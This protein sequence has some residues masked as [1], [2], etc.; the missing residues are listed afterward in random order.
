MESAVV[1]VPDEI[2]GQAIVLFV[3]P[4]ENEKINQENIGEKIRLHL[5]KVIGPVIQIKKTFI[6]K[7]LPK[8]S[9]G[10]LMRRVLRC[11]LNG[12]EVGDLSTCMNS[13]S[14]EDIRLLV[15]Q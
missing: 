9:T 8:T 12:E 4:N 11:V 3:V 15:G 14:V 2:T 1:A 6:V 5:R 13:A 10:K 7:E